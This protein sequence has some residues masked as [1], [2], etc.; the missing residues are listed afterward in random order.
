[1]PRPVDIWLR[2]TKLSPFVFLLAQNDWSHYSAHYAVVSFYVSSLSRTSW[3]DNCAT[4]DSFWAAE[5]FSSL[6]ILVPC[7]GQRKRK[8]RLSSIDAELNV[9]RLDRSHFASFNARAID[10]A[11]M[12]KQRFLAAF[13]MFIRASIVFAGLLK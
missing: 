12:I 10:N 9:L 11:L 5:N 8:V 6:E 13:K 4:I 7:C 1:M 3:L 2:Y